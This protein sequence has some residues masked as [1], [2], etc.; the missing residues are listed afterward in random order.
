[1]AGHSRA[2]AVRLKYEA[3]AIRQNGHPGFVLIS[4]KKRCHAR[5]GEARERAQEGRR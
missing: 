1:M 2:M 4:E 5:N 3:F